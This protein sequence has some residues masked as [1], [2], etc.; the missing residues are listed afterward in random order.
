MQ[1]L[2]GAPSKLPS[3][4]TKHGET[5]SSRT[6]PGSEYLNTL[7]LISYPRWRDKRYKLLHPNMSNLKVYTQLSQLIILLFTVNRSIVHRC[8]LRRCLFGIWEG[9]FSAG[10]LGHSEVKLSGW[11][12]LQFRKVITNVII[13]TNSGPNERAVCR[14]LLWTRIFRSI[15]RSKELKKNIWKRR[16]KKKTNC[17]V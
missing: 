5:Q 1:L 13:M 7:R 17:I 3:E 10:A 4:G 14:N 12:A 16:R 9:V 2:R 15:N 6:N 8:S 11:R